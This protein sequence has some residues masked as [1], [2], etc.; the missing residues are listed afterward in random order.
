LAF[1]LQLKT[2]T[3]SRARSGTIGWRTTP[4]IRAKI[5]ELTPIANASV[6]TAAAVNPGVLISCLNAN[7]KSWIIKTLVFGEMRAGMILDSKSAH[8][9]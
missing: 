6:N 5:A 1:C 7:L 2:F 9:V 3:T 8:E 4:L